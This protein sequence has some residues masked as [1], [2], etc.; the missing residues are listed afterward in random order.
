MSA[1]D[2]DETTSSGVLASWFLVRGESLLCSALVSRGK[3]SY[4]GQFLATNMTSL[5]VELRKRC[6]HVSEQMCSETVWDSCSTHFCV[7]SPKLGNLSPKI[8]RARTWDWSMQKTRNVYSMTASFSVARILL[9]LFYHSL[10]RTIDMTLNPNFVNGSVTLEEP[11]TSPDL[12]F[13]VLKL[14]T[15][16]H[17]S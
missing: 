2:G 12:R 4:Y 7:P 8:S 1:D 3:C 9:L 17:S 11:E 10:W 5:N 6:T 15:I 14:G 13:L 16:T